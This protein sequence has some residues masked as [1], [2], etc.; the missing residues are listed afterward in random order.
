MNLPG[1]LTPMNWSWRFEWP[2]LHEEHARV[3]A[4]MAHTSGRDGARPK[5]GAAVPGYFPL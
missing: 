1:T 3:L 4:L 5:P 2:M